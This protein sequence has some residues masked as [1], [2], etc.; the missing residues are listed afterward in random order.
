[1]V[2]A[3]LIDAENLL[4]QPGPALYEAVCS[5]ISALPADSSV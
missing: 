1:L 3:P 4:R 5:E 2:E